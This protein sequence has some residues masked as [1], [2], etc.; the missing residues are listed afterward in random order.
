MG[1][2]STFILH[3]QGNFQLWNEVWDS[4]YSFE[5]NNIEHSFLKKCFNIFFKN[6]NFI[7]WRLF[8]L[9]NKK[10]L[11]NSSFLFFDCFQI[12]NFILLKKKVKK[13]RI[14]VGNID[15]LKLNGWLIINFFFFFTKKRKRI[16]KKKI[17]K[18]I[19]NTFFKLNFFSNNNN[20]N[21]TFFF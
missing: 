8:N 11:K 14:Y 15:I 19:K 4:K 13:N 3:R 1:Q 6:K 18:K 9:E 2:A 17:K 16:Q 20:N 7:H 10:V 21:E 12:E 5:K